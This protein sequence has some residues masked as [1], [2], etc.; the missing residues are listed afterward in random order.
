MAAAPMPQPE[1]GAGAAAPTPDPTQSA[2]GGGAPASPEQ[3][4][5]AAIYQHLKSMAQANPVMSAGLAK[6]AEGIQEAQ[7]AMIS[8]PQQQP[9]STNPTY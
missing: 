1:A 8:Q 6:A 4:Q 7:S 5:L 3:M 2:G 9:T